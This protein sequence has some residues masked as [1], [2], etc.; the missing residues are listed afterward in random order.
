MPKFGAKVTPKYSKG[1]GRNKEYYR[2]GN[3]GWW[4]S[5][6]REDAGLHRTQV[7]DAM[8]FP[9]GAIKDIEEGRRIPKPGTV[10]KYLDALVLLTTHNSVMYKRFH[11]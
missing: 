1:D 7:A 10:H 9:R 6:Q 8:G 2:L 11:A 4:L 3:I 5:V